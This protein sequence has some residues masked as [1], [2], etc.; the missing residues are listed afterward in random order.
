M[1]TTLV[2]EETLAQRPEPAIV[3]AW[4]DELVVLARFQGKSGHHKFCKPFTAWEESG[5]LDILTISD[6]VFCIFDQDTVTDTRPHAAR[7]HVALVMIA[8]SG[9]NGRNGWISPLIVVNAAIVA[10]LDNGLG[11]IRPASRC[12]CHNDNQNLFASCY[13]V[14]GILAI[15]FRGL[16]VHSRQTNVPVWHPILQAIFVPLIETQ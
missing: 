16:S 15:R 5:I 12:Q 9:V 11:R 1:S 13:R 2:T 4:G 14:H 3:S 7:P 10:M 6:D 8:A